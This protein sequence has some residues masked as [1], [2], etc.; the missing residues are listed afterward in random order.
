MCQTYLT[1]CTPSK[2]EATD[3]PKK[4]K[5]RKV[6]KLWGDNGVDTGLTENTRGVKSALS[7]LQ[8]E[9]CS[10]SVSKAL[11]WERKMKAKV[12]AEK[13]APILK[14]LNYIFLTVGFQ[15]AFTIFCLP[16]CS[17]LQ[18]MNASQCWKPWL[19]YV[20]T[21]KTQHL[22]KSWDLLY[23]LK[24]HFIRKQQDEQSIVAPVW[25]VSGPSWALRAL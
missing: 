2:E 6:K 24:S 19:K 3:L 21:H 7:S 13:C 1:T 25:S 20:Y 5:I 8:Y 12:V 4:N 14:S 18:S 11:T 9:W 17:V 15:F 23:R 22:P 16:N 10:T